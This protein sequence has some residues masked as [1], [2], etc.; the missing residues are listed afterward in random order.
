MP[1]IESSVGLVLRTYPLTETSLIAH[2]LTPGCGRIATV[3]KGARGPKSAFR[4]RLDLFYV[5]EFGFVRSRRSEL[6]TLREIALQ[7]TH[8]A[9]RRNITHLQQACYCAAL[10]EQATETETPLPEVFQL[11]RLLLA[12]LGSTEPHASPIYAFEIKLLGELGLEPDLST[13]SL[14]AAAKAALAA[15]TD[16]E[17]PAVVALRLSGS[18]SRELRQFLHGFLIYHLGRIPKGRDA[19]LAGG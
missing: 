8:P 1:I 6:H 4:G 3:A 17:W 12:N 5:A 11:M 14:S 9:L 13:T 10:V 16:A 18:Q 19:A 15:L 7:E 2:W